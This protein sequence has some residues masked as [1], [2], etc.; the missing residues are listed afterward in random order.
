M[1]GG[2]EGEGGEDE[3]VVGFDLGRKKDQTKKRKGEEERRRGSARS[4]E[5]ESEHRT[6]TEEKDVAVAKNEKL[7]LPHSTSPTPAFLT[8]LTTAA[9]I[10]FS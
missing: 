1:G 6:T 2:E 5:N 9:S 7:T 8:P 4:S 3:G 10:T